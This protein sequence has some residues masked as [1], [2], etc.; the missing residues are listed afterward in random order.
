ME[1]Q[2]FSSLKGSGIV[3]LLEVRFS[4]IYGAVFPNVKEY[5]ITNSK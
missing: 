3:P 1:Y 2:A 5:Q 4:V